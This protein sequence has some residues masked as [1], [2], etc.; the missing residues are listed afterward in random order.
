MLSDGKLD[1][2]Y[3]ILESKALFCLSTSF[4]LNRDFRPS[5]GDE[6]LSFSELS[7]ASAHAIF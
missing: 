4:C 5:W 2:V 3:R 1:L 7:V 6:C